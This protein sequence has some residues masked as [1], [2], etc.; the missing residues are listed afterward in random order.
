MTKLTKA[1]FAMI[2]YL[3]LMQDLTTKTIKYITEKSQMLDMGYAAIQVLH[4]TLRVYVR[5]YCG[6]W[7]YEFP[8]EAEEYISLTGDGNT[9]FPKGLK[10]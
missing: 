10:V 6:E 3:T 7:K 8:K 9:E 2:C 4:P 1:E 5:D